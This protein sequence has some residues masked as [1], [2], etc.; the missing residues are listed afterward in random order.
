MADRIWKNAVNL[1]P[2]SCPDTGTEAKHLFWHFFKALTGA[3]LDGPTT[4]GAWTVL[5]SSGYV[6]AVW[7]GALDGV[8]RLGATYGPA[9]LIQANSGAN[10]TWVALQAP[11]EF[12]DGTG[13]YYAVLEL[14]ASNVSN[15]VIGK[16]APTGGTATATPTIS[17]ANKLSMALG[18]LN[19]AYGNYRPSVLLS[20]K[21]DVILVSQ[22]VGSNFNALW[23]LTTLADRHSIDQYPVCIY[24]RGSSTGSAA[25][26]I[27]LGST[28]L[29]FKMKSHTGNADVF[30]YTMVGNTYN[31][32]S[33]TF[34]SMNVGDAVSGQMPE[35]PMYVMITTPLHASVRGRIP[36]SYIVPSSSTGFV[37][38]SVGP[39]TGQSLGSVLFPFCDPVAVS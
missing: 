28:S 4:P 29:Y 17:D 8:D 39:Q 38:P 20:A 16:T 26:Y 18:N 3:L 37:R 1:G 22:L 21:G 12:G 6:D 11:A 7:D 24:S 36:D 32:S 23:M 33:S 5:G 30:G 34:A 19:G 10:H 14:L 25:N 15:I 35:L 27:D 2:Y 13:Q 9:N 31:S